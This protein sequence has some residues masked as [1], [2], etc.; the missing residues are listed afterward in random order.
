M[1]V[2]IVTL[3]PGD[4]RPDC[5]AAAITLLGGVLGYFFLD[6]TVAAPAPLGQMFCSSN[7]SDD[8]SPTGNAPPGLCS[9]AARGSLMKL[10]QMNG[11]GTVLV[12]YTGAVLCCDVHSI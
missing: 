8:G 3:Q 5:T 11:V 7:A 2:S 12:L 4:L 1:C 6:E 9:A 10:L